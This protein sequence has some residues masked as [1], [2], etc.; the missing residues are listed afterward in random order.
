MR[1]DACSVR[2]RCW[3][4][5]PEN[6]MVHFLVNDERYRC[7][8]YADDARSPGD[9]LHSPGGYRFGRVRGKSARGSLHR[10]HGT[11]R[12][13]IEAIVDS[14]LRRMERELER[15]GIRTRDPR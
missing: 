4:R 13:V 11:F 14:K 8:V 2:A 3:E 12:R 1:Q 15:R 6:E 5:V 7:L 9:E 10:V